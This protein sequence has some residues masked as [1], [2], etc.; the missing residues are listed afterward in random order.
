MKIAFVSTVQGHKW[1]GSEYLWS[2]CANRLLAAKHRV[3][4]GVSEDFRGAAPL[5]KMQTAG[6]EV[7]FISPGFG[8]LARLREK[9]TPAYQSLERFQPDILIVS[10]GSAYDP[11]YLSAL[12]KFLVATKIPFIFICHFNAETFWVDEP[13]RVLMAQIFAKAEKAVFVSQENLRLTERQLAAAIPRPAVIVPPLC[14]SAPE[15]LAWPEPTTDGPWRLACVARLEPRWKGQDVL[16]EVLAD[17]R[18]RGRN[19]QLNLFGQGAE[20]DYLQRLVKFYEL[21]KKV[22]FA[23][24]A[25]PEKIWQEHHLQVLAARGEGG[26]MVITEG[27]ICGRIAVTTRC[28]FTPEYITDG[29]TGFLADFATTAC[30]GAALESAWHR[31]TEWREMGCRAHSAIQARLG[32]FNAPERLLELI[33]ENRR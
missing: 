16:F 19:Y 23:G 8:R 10:S 31:R 14:V 30:F 3:F 2:A 5:E 18:W 7:E 11:V 28:G 25:A 24:F 4:V 32:D 15:P 21:E 6:A 22:H 20:A 17:E 33:L 26:P 1:P 27:M 12:G 13:M 9:I 29:E